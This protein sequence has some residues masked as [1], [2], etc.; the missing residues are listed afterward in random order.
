MRKK[1]S[2]EPVVLIVLAI[3]VAA[4]LLRRLLKERPP[5]VPG[6]EPSRGF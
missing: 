5:L 2:V 4:L 3:L 6:P 1:I